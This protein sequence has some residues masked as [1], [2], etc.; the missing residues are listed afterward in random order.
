M[1]PDTVT[2]VLTPTGTAPPPPNSSPG[3][4]DSSRGGGGLSLAGTAVMA[5]FLGLLTALVIVLSAVLLRRR[6]N[7]LA[8]E[9]RPEGECRIA[10]RG[11]EQASLRG[12]DSPRTHPIAHSS[13]N[14]DAPSA[15]WSLT[16]RADSQS[17]LLPQYH[18]T[19][20]HPAES[21]NSASSFIPPSPLTSSPGGRHPSPG[22]ERPRS[23]RQP[24]R[25]RPDVPR[26]AL[27]DTNT[28]PSSLAD[29][30]PPVLVR[31]SIAA[32]RYRHMPN[33]KRLAVELNSSS[34]Q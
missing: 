16:S 34:L 23:A 19:Q 15:S 13:R 8:R 29:P 9:K 4:G 17:S 3:N 24:R 6:R 14:S 22:P 10:Q 32:V 31:P 2:G 27:S 26:S 5:A 30:P 25:H 18:G 33:G 20:T 7:R 11:P 12:P 28:A 21:P 1:P